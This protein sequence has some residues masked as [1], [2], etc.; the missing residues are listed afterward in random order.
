MAEGEVDRIMP[1][2]RDAAPSNHPLR[3]IGELNRKYGNRSDTVHK[4][5]PEIL[6]RRDYHAH[7]KTG[8]YN[9]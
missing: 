1:N 2:S 9:H 8:G 6:D 7:P 5:D 4:T 3:P